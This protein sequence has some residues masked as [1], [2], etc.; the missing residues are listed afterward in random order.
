MQLGQGSARSSPF[1]WNVSIEMFGLSNL[2]LRRLFIASVFSSSVIGI[3]GRLFVAFSLPAFCSA[4][5]SA[6]I[7][8]F[9]R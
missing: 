3:N 5:T 2:A 7:S 1:S 4:S 6:M 8:F 9:I